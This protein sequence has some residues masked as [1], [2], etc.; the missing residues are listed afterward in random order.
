MKLL[1]TD[2]VVAADEAS[3]NYALRLAYNETAYGRQNCDYSIC[4]TPI[5]TTRSTT[6]TAHL[7]YLFNFTLNAKSGGVLL[8]YD[9]DNNNND[10]DNRYTLQ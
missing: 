1:P 4:K 6:S 10:G 7:H 9:D 3:D 2:R 5:K 8:A